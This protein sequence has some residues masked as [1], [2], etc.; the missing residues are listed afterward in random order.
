MKT[1]LGNQNSL[2]QVV[3]ILCI[4]LVACGC[5]PKKPQSP[6][7]NETKNES[8]LPADEKVPTE[9]DSI[10]PSTEP[11][12]DPASPPLAEAS[13]ES[14]SAD[15]PTAPTEPAL[16]EEPPQTWSVQRIVALAATGPIVIDV[17]ANI[18][19]KSL[20]EAA[21]AATER[22]VAQIAKDLEK[23][24][25]WSKLLDHPLI[26]SG[27]L[28][29][30]V[31]EGEQRAQLISMYNTDG[32]EEVD[33]EELPAF[34]TR[35]LARGA[36][37]RFTDI[38]SAPNATSSRTPWD[39]LDT[40]QDS[41]L[42]KSE[43][44][45]MPN[46]VAKHDLNADGIVTISELQ[47]NRST[48]STAM[49][50]GM[51]DS[52]SA[53]S[54]GAEQNPQQ[55]A[56]KLLEHYASFGTVSRDQ[57]PGWSDKRWNECD[58]NGDMLIT[59]KELEAITTVHPEL[60]LK[61]QFQSNPEAGLSL[62]AKVGNTSDF[63]WASRLKTAGQATGKS[64][65]LAVVV[66]DS[67]TAASQASVRGQLSAALSNPQIAMFFRNQ[68]QL[69][70]SAFDVLDA[71]NDDKLSDEE[72]RNAWDWITAIRGSRIL[73]RWMF[74][75][76]AWFRMADI[77]AD[78]RVTAIELQKLAGYLATLDQDQDGS[79]SP[80]EVPLA[81]R[82]EIART[83][84]RIASNAPTGTEIAPTGTGWFAASDSNNDGFIGKSEFLGS[85]DD[86]LA[87]DADNDGFIAATEAYKSPTATLQ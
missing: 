80:I 14:K 33:D 73:A 43:I 31:P 47:A 86:F 71:D 75:E 32:D 70:E 38:G 29:N 1:K 10:A 21:K 19:G 20:D 85:N 8:E 22:A 87:Y 6:I 79:I 5:S 46:V 4:G 83:D 23:P 77:D 26:R 81:T 13:D 58:T 69:S 18:G 45:D 41:S 55:F 11:S 52:K 51:L 48:M 57:W 35:G 30:L 9:A 40:N 7:E 61:I 59:S 76:S 12:T 3:A 53:I 66:T 49:G 50:G 64:S 74:A 44:A 54:V 72:F 60:D 39:Q 17:S 84:D 25:T 65:V 2:M 16:S 36:A 78:G 27:W 63:S 24:W 82:L 28:G 56:R 62:S 15:S 37:F 34:L 67:Y 42:D 68:L